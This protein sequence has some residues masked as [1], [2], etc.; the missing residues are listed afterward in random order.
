MLEIRSTKPHTY[1]IDIKLWSEIDPEYMLGKIDD[2]GNVIE[3]E[4]EVTIDGKQAI[5]KLYDVFKKQFQELPL[6]NFTLLATKGINGKQVQQVLTAK[7]K[8][9]IKPKEFIAVYLYKLIETE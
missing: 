9:Q 6:L 3:N 7:H 5:I 8:R 2:K 1:D 4:I